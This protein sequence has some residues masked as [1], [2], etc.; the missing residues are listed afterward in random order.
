MNEDRGTRP[1]NVIV[2]YLD[3]GPS[4]PLVDTRVEAASEDEA[5][6][7]AECMALE[8]GLQVRVL[9]VS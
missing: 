1:Y 4:E 7:I 3:R 5:V 9:G 8:N 2:K 6:T